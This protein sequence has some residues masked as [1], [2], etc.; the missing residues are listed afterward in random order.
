MLAPRHLAHVDETFDARCYFDEC[1]VVG[2]HHYLA[3]HVVAHL[4]VLVECIPRM[5]RKLLQTECDTLALVVEVQNHYV[6]FLI[7]FHN[8]VRVAHASPREVGDMNQTIYAAQVDEHTVAGDV[9]HGALEHLALL[10]AADDFLLLLLQFGFDECL[11]THH[12][13]LVFL[14]DLDNLELHGLAYKD[15]IVADGLHV[16]LAAGQECLDAEYVHDHATLC[17]ALHVA[18]HD[19][20][21]LHGLVHAVPRAACAC[22]LVRE[23]QL[24]FLVLL[25]LNVHFHRVAH[26]EVGV[27]AEFTC[28]NDSI[29]LEADVHYHFALVHCD[30]RTIDHVVVVD[31][32]QG[33]GVGFLLSLTAH[34]SVAVTLGIAFPI[35]V[36]NGCNVL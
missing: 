19:F 35:E 9:L 24:A 2:H 25:V 33:A 18:L 17:A 29:A 10:E 26:L 21:V 1:A 16:N 15:V 6:K 31:F 32:V 5:R 30:N 7:E 23:D 11:V 27:V 4:Q 22:L 3:L 36:F 28:G 20:L 13:V 34:L 8:L 12:H 14:I